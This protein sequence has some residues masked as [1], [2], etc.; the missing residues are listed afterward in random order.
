MR[1]YLNKWLNKIKQYN[2]RENQLLKAIKVSKTNFENKNKMKLL[3]AYLKWRNLCRK[4]NLT[5]I[6]LGLKHLL[7]GLLEKKFNH[8]I[9]KTEIINIDIKRGLS[10]YDALLNG[11]KNMA[12]CISLRNLFLKPYFNKWN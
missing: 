5:P 1:N 7:K 2:K 10:V 12:K 6:Q 8:I 11:D 9:K 3:K 4:K